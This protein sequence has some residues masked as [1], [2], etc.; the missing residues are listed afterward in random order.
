ML[1]KLTEDLDRAVRRFLDDSQ[2]DDGEIMAAVFK[3]NNEIGRL[4]RP[5]GDTALRDLQLDVNEVTKAAKLN[6]RASLVEAM[7]LV[8][9]EVLKLG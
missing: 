9:S 1:S 8:K 4:L 2:A 6:D 3:L 5:T 7:S